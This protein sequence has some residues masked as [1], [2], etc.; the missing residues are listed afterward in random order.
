MSE[1]DRVGNISLS[2]IVAI[3][4]LGMFVPLTGTGLAVKSLY[5]LLLPF[6]LFA[7]LSLHSASLFCPNFP[8]NPFPLAH[9]Y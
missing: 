9:V 6:L 4:D 3:G 1:S 5:A 7:L 2:M 8:L